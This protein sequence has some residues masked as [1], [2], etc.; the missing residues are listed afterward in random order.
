MT[1]LK[2]ALD[3]F[4]NG[5]P[6]AVYQPQ[7]KARA[8]VM[9]WPTLGD[10]QPEW[11]LIDYSSYVEEGVN[12]NAV[13]YAAIRYKWQATQATQL[14]AYGGSMDSP[15]PLDADHP[16]AKLVARP[17]VWQDWRTMQALADAYLNVSGNAYFW[18]TRPKSGKG[19]PE[20]IWCP[21]PDRVFVVP[22]KPKEG[23]P[24]SLLGYLYVPE[25]QPYSRGTPVLPQNMMHV[26]LPNPGD[27][28]GGLGEGLSPL[29]P[30]AYSIDVDNQITRFIKTF[31]EKG[32]VP[33]YWFS[34]S[35]PIDDS[36]YSKLQERIQEIYGGVEGWVKPGIL[37]RGGDIKQIGLTFEQ[38]GF[39]VIDARNE[40]RIAGPLGVPLILIGSRYGLE[41]STL[42]NYREA[43]LAFWEDW[44]IPE[45]ML[46]Q[47]EYRY[48]LQGD[49]GEFVMF[50]LSRVPALQKDI[51]QLAE[52]A[53]KMWQMG[54]PANIAYATVGLSVEEIPG[55]DT[56]YVPLGVIPVGSTGGEEEPSEEGSPEA[57]EDTRKALR[58]MPP[59]KAR[60][61]R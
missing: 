33:P 54:T 35:E 26:K 37:D 55:G 51:P 5:F 49:N 15:E 31:F 12:M 53:Y 9:G 2:I 40:S 3:I 60:A 28:L 24:P 32:G 30:G 16:L 41:R 4:K 52:A 27:P 7:V 36:T 58:L 34:F 56:G 17:N 38:M 10:V 29:S 50:D 45:L 59:K 13:I 46:F 14:R 18:L 19:L 42:A 61:R 25:G 39:P 48:Y 8:A 1:R 44:M 43:R 47:E 23:E 57:E 20:S 11:H 6:S 22:D 21:R